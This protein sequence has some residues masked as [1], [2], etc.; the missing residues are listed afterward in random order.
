[1]AGCGGLGAGVWSGGHARGGRAVRDCDGG[2]R[3]CDGAAFP[4]VSPRAIVAPFLRGWGWWAKIE[5]Q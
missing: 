3:G 4:G 2:P 1:V 5:Q